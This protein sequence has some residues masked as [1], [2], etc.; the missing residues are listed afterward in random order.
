MPEA[1]TGHRA[2][3]GGTTQRLSPS[4]GPAQ[5]LVGRAFRLSP[6][7]NELSSVPIFAGTRGQIANLALPLTWCH[8]SPRSIDRPARETRFLIS[9]CRRFRHSPGLTL[10]FYRCF[11]L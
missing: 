10:S 9:V 6:T 11:Q 2:T 7:Q 3:R 8:F 1:C 4:L 5:S